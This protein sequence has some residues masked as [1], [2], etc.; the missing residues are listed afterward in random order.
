[1]DAITETAFLEILEKKKEVI[2]S[3]DN[4]LSGR[5]KRAEAW[6]WVG[7]R[8]AVNTGKSF[9]VEQLQ[10]KWNNLQNR[11][12]DRLKDSKNTGGGPPKKLSANDLLA[13]RIM[14]KTNPKL[15]MVPGAM[16]NAADLENVE[17]TQDLYENQSKLYIIAHFY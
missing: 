5:T 15:A 16:E 8:V 9:T 7:E 14:G 10:K 6:V 17:P 11:L 1:M 12:K 4:T 3:K 13:W 2:T